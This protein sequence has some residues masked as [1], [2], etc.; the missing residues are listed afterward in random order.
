MSKIVDKIK[1][2]LREFKLSSFA[3][4]NATSIFLM[5]V[6]I[7]IF[8]LDSYNSMPKEQY[9]E[10]S[11]PTVYVNTPYFGNT[12]ADIENLVTRP[13]E[14]ELQSIVGVDNITSSSV[15]DFSVIIVEFDADRDIDEAVRKVKDAID[16]AKSEL[17]TDLTTDPQVLEIDLSQIPIMTVN[18][19]GD[20]TI[21][22]LKTYAE[23]L[24]EEFENLSEVSEADIKGALDREVK[25]DVD[26]PKMESLKVS[27]TDIENAV[28]AENLTMSGGEIVSDNFRRGVRIIGE[29]T[30]M[31]QIRNMI[32]KSESQRPIYL[33]DIATVT[34]G[35]EELKSIARSDGFSVVS[36]DIIKRSGENLI[37]AADKVK[38]IVEE[39]ENNVL[40]AD[41]KVS[42]FND[43]SENTKR[44]VSN[45]ENSIISGMIL[46]ILVLLFFMGLRNATFVGVAIPLSMLTGIMWLYLTGV[47]MNMMVLF[48]L[49]L[50]L[51]ML[52]DNAIVVVE[53]IY[54][55]FQEGYS[56]KDAAKFG[57]GEVA[58]PIIASTATTLAA[59][60]PL[61]FWPGIVG[62]F[63]KY[64]PI[65]LILVLSSSLIVALVINPV[66]TA[67]FM[68][69]DE[70]ADSAEERKKKTRNIGIF[71]LGAIVFGFVFHS[72]GLDWARNLLGI[73][74]VISTI[75]FFAL[76]PA[77]FYFQNKVMPALERGYDWF[78]GKALYKKMPIVVFVGTFVLMICSIMLLAVKSPKVVFFPDTQPIY[79][80]VFLEL[81][82]GRD[83]EA[84]DK[85]V[86]I[87]ESQITTVLEPYQDVVESVLTQIGENTSDPN[88]TPEP[89][90]SPNKARI[91]V[92][93]VPADERNGV[94]TSKI[95]EDIRANLKNMPGVQ[96]VV[97]QNAA[98][99]PTGKPVNIEIQGENIDELAQLS[100]DLIAYV[101]KQNIPGIE[102]L[103]ADVKIGKPELLIHID[104]EAARRY[105]LSTYAIAD[106]LRTSVY[107]KEVSTYKDGEDDY[108]IQL[109][110]DP[111]Y[112]N[113][114]GALMNQKIT[115]R[116]PANGQLTQVPISAVAT[117]EYSSTYSS[118]NRKDLER[119]ITI[120]SN[121]LDGYN[122]NEIVEEVKAVFADYKMPNG[123][124]YAFTG[125]QEQQA[126]DMQFLSG[127]FILSIFL[128]FIILVSQFN[129][130]ISPFIIL[131]SVFFS[132][133]GVFLG[134]VVTGS[135]IAV[136]LTGVGIISLAGI[137][138]N[139]AIVLVDYINLLVTRRRKELGFENMWMLDKS[140]VKSMIIKGGSTRLR[141]VLLTAITTILGLIPLAI[142]LNINFFT[143]ISDLDAQFFIGGDNKDF[144][145][146]MAWTVIYGLTFS[147]FLTLVVIPAMYW[148]AYRF[149]Y[150]I[151]NRKSKKA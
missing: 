111:K 17:P 94:K 124:S 64:L 103:K 129:S 43:Q 88:S 49:I 18:V 146:P 45:L 104:R 128:I 40:P 118:I 122:A 82:I 98:G 65:T 97:D 33:K 96:I 4:D 9:P 36:I 28:K 142:G 144:W 135:D 23:Y 42:I 51:G 29:F 22:Q 100:E 50:A 41:L 105:E 87:V 150:I 10:V 21:D 31:D 143:I 149:M 57:A 16:L 19:S 5:T 7:F 62:E 130:I 68:K 70:K 139:N 117:V 46:V 77:S 84:T 133:I 106:A 132:T 27:F 11:F 109:R 66:F 3:V 123:I 71:I 110:L 145:G 95:M 69:V 92:T 52:V 140:D 113:N 14:Q 148:L 61:A 107:G 37:A 55:Y 2:N 147:T 58:V 108:P 48:A 76:R 12:A 125:E 73:T 91:T 67:Y 101:N 151:K 114:V 120:Y 79:I 127:A 78:V 138:V 116:N 80:N 63:M 75:N 13:I 89:G 20:Y 59:F 134:Y 119:A 38:A 56:A 26:L 86:R 115:F 1:D 137:V 83:I 44:E 121:V 25:I 47:T 39:A 131:M 54:R 81:P 6:M 32:V 72:I 15:Q 141:P 90:A 136:I 93:F 74:A 60:L 112:R 30:N 85:A 53:N 35:Y 102:E 34:Y 8:G 126:E 99:P 24:E